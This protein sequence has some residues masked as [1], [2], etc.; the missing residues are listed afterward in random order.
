MTICQHQLDVEQINQLSLSRGRRD[1]AE[2]T[3]LTMCADEVKSACQTDCDDASPYRDA[4][5]RP[6]SHAEAVELIGRSNTGVLDEIIKD[7]ADLGRSLRVAVR[8][9]RRRL[10]VKVAR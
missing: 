1:I 7:F 5:L 3:A 2:L 8:R 4:V 6:I 10:P 9:L